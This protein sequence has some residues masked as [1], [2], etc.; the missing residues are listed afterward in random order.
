MIY[1]NNQL[2]PDDSSA[3]LFLVS[4]SVAF[5]KFEDHEAAIHFHIDQLINVAISEGENPKALIEDYLEISFCD[6]H[7]TEEIT[8]F[9]METDKMQTALW[10][11]QER[12]QSMDES[13]TEDSLLGGNSVGKEE[14]IQLYAEITLRSYLETLATFNNG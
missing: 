3:Q 4:N 6:G 7:T 8:S 5:E 13:L 2:M 11:L 1:Y 12:W 10:T 14:A 9:L